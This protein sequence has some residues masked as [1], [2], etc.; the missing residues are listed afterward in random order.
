DVPGRLERERVS[1]RERLGRS[2]ARHQPT[3]S[4]PGEVRPF[5]VR[6]RAADGG[7]RAGD[8][9]LALRTHFG[10]S[11]LPAEALRVAHSPPRDGRDDAHFFTAGERRREAVEEADVLVA[12]VD[13]HETAYALVVEQ[14]IAEPGVTL[15]QVLDHLRDGGAFGLNLF[16]SSGERSERGGDAYRNGHGGLLSGGTDGGG[17]PRLFDVENAS[18]RPAQG[19]ALA[20]PDVHGPQTVRQSIVGEKLPDRAGPSEQDA[21]G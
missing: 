19:A 15:L 3:D 6:A 12:H 2:R 20:R 18:S 9:P 14:P 1:M 21:Q 5:D 8:L 13:V 4:G 11:L 10:E 7:R 16:F 17:V